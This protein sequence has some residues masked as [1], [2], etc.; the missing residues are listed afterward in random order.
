M[1]ATSCGASRAEF[2]AYFEGSMNAVA[3]HIQGVQ[4]LK[5]SLHLHELRSM[6]SFVPPVSWRWVRPS[7]E[8]LLRGEP[9]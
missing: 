9:A 8:F 5:A 2:D 4:R 3:L 1:V 6:V 7:E